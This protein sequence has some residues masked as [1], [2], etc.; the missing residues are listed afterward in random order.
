M[1][2]LVQMFS[3]IFVI[4]EIGNTLMIALGMWAQ[5]VPYRNWYLSAAFSLLGLFILVMSSLRDE[6]GEYMFWWNGKP[7]AGSSPESER[8]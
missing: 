8:S 2:A 5:N 6:H 1:R 7:E 3:Y 4:C